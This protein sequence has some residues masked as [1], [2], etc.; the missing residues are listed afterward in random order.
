MGLSRRKRKKLRELQAQ[1]IDPEADENRKRLEAESTK[2]PIHGCNALLASDDP[3]EK[4]ADARL[5]GQAATRRWNIPA[6]VYDTAP[7]LMRSWLDSGEPQLQ[8]EAVKLLTKLHAQN[9]ADRP[10]QPHQVDLNVSVDGNPYRD[11]IGELLTPE[12]I[13][14][15][16][17]IDV[18][19]F[20]T[21]GAE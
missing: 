11:T 3:R 10:K 15:V 1:G 21:G 6:S 17:A 19:S 20:P 13:R 18:E 7:E 9:Q 2:S 16:A 8:L 14:A 12:Q 4:A 5:I